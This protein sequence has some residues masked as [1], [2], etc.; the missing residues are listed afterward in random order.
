M[1]ITNRKAEDESTVE[2]IFKKKKKCASKE[3]KERKLV[4]YF[5]KNLVLNNI[6]TGS[7]RSF[8]RKRKAQIKFKHLKKNKERK[9]KEEGLGGGRG[10]EPT[11]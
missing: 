11:R 3:K 7:L 9:E 8:A 1:A 2:Y 6:A 10:S 4:K 5:R